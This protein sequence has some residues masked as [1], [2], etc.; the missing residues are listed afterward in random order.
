MLTATDIARVLSHY[1]LGTLQSTTS[2]YRGNVNETAFVQTNKGRFVVRRNQRTQSEE[3]LRYRHNLIQ[4]VRTYDVP[5]PRLIPT[6]EDDTLLELDDGRFYEVMAFVKGESFNPQRPQQLTNVGAMLAH[7]HEAARGFAP[8]PQQVHLR[9]A[10]QDM[11]GLTENLLRHDLMG[12][13]TPTLSW[14]DGRIARLRKQLPDTAYAALPQ[15]AIHGDIHSENVLFD[16]DSDQVMALIDF[17]QVEWDTPIA[18]LVDA[19]V[20]FASVDKPATI[21]WGVFKGPLDEDRAAQLI[22]G[23]ASVRHLSRK[24]IEA[25]PVLLEVHW[26]RGELG[27]VL[28]TPEGS[29]DYHVS[30]LD[31][32]LSLS[33]WLNEHRDRLVKQWSDILERHKVFATAA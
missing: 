33:Y 31:Q 30:V 13:L 4:H 6:L 25:I 11:L 17:D 22:A 32:G 21:Q 28:S 3:M 18:D 12:D 1:D 23:Y 8:P 27:R 7:Y 9:Y 26:L 24:E 20:A 15:M 2:A 14:Y 16:N 29:P 10:P 5:A 19:L